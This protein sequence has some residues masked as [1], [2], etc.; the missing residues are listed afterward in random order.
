MLSG[1]LQTVFGWTLC[2]GSELN[3]RSLRNYPMEANGAEM[4][5]R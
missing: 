2:V 1:Q 3:P 4:W 5:F